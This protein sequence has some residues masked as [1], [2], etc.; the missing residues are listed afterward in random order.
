MLPSINFLCGVGPSVNFLCSHGPF[1]LLSMWSRHIPSI[2]CAATEPFMNIS[3][4]CVTF[5]QHFVWPRDLPFR[6]GT[7]RELFMPP[8]HLLCGRSPS[9]SF[10]F[11]HK[12]FC[13]LSVWSQ[14]FPCSSAN[15]CQLSVRLQELLSTFRASANFLVNVL[16]GHCSFLQLSVQLQNLPSTF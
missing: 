4:S 16:C 6:R 1:H 11:S 14:G 13:Q 3:S 12:G 7:F 10:L 2:F 9:V 15:F 8:Q 5:S